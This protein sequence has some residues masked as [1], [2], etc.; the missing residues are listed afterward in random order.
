M[1]YKYI[2]AKKFLKPLLYIKN[3]VQNA[4]LSILK[5][6]F[7]KILP[8]AKKFDITLDKTKKILYNNIRYKKK[9]KLLTLSN[10]KKVRN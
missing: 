10:K 4:N 7:L 6:Y 5:R 2:L 1:I 8:I 9:S 3:Y